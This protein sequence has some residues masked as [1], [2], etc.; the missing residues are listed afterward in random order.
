MPHNHYS[1]VIFLQ[2]SSLVFLGVKPKIK[3]EFQNEDLICLG[4]Q[5]WC[6]RGDHADILVSFHELPDK[7]KRKL[8]VLK[9]VN[10]LDF[11]ALEGPEHLKLLLL[12]KEMVIRWLCWVPNGLSFCIRCRLVRVVF[13]GI[14]DEG[15]PLKRYA[16]KSGIAFWGGVTPGT[17]AVA[18]V[19][20]IA[21]KGSRGAAFVDG[22]SVERV[23]D[24][25]ETVAPVTYP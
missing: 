25:E 21:L 6:F 19:V 23:C 11:L 9:I 3:G 7:G 12:L 8:V 15:N 16:P 13:H 18:S 5:N 10:L 17:S 2:I 1:D 24:S 22:G 14:L 20:T 4:K